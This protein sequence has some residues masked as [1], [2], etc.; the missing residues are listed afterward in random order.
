M[1]KQF[2]AADAEL[3]DFFT[4]AI[5]V[6]AQSYEPVGGAFDPRVGDLA[7]IHQ[8]AHGA[9]ARYDAV[10]DTMAK[11]PAEH[12][13]TLALTYAPHGWPTWLADALS[14]RWGRG[15]FVALAAALPRAVAAVAKRYPSEAPATAARCLEFF[16][17]AG[18]GGA[19]QLFAKLREECDVLRDAAL[20]A[21]DELRIARVEAEAGAK[22]AQRAAVEARGAAL[23]AELMGRTDERAT[24]RFERRLRAAS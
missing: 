23:F 12:R 4:S 19:D 13:R 10:A 18:R 6:R 1:G 9:L 7:L 24:A 21:Y 8:I 22:K 3:S 16:V 14:P 17:D 5:G 20:A 15:C 2:L 11:L